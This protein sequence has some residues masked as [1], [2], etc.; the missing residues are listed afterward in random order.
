MFYRPRRHEDTKCEMANLEL[1][2]AESD[3]RNLKFLFFVPSCL[4]GENIHHQNSSL[5]LRRG[6][7]EDAE[8]V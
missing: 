7:K 2:M 6:S 4:R 3:I 1:S 8:D 5:Y